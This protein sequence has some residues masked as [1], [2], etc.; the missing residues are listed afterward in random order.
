MFA[1]EQQEEARRS[2]DDFGFGVQRGG[3]EMMHYVRDGLDCA[4][5]AE[6]GQ[7]SV[8]LDNGAAVGRG[9]A[10]ILK[11]PPTKNCRAMVAVWFLS[12]NFGVADV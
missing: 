5:P 7:L 6:V 2:D 8:L 11:L 12:R 1:D 4:V 10:N 3:V 9:E